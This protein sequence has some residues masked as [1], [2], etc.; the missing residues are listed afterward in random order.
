MQV[1][2]LYSGTDGESHF[3][4]IEVSQQEAGVGALS[5]RLPVESLFLRT[6]PGDYEPARHLA[7]GA[8]S[9]STSTVKWRSRRGRPRAAS[10]RGRSSSPRI[11]PGMAT[12]P[13]TSAALDDQS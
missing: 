6:T 9:S 10:G 5:R 8:S 2:R 13:E 4:D 12:S 11:S 3:E 7:P 1:I